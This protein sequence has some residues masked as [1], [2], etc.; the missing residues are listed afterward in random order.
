VIVDSSGKFWEKA[1]EFCFYGL[2]EI[3]IARISR[4]NGNKSVSVCFL[5]SDFKYCHGR[6]VLF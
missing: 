3:R 5:Q 2:E 4:L 6:L 1:R